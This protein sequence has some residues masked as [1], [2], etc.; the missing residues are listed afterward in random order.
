M[1]Y[2]TV[3]DVRGRV[4]YRVI[5]AGSAPSQTQVETWITESE[6]MLD[7]TLASVGIPGPFGGASQ[8]A[9]LRAWSLDYPEGHVRMAY[10]AAGGD[11]RND[12]G[13][14][15]LD[16]FYRRLDW[17][18]ENPAQADA[19]LNPPSSSDPATGPASYWTAG[20]RTPADRVPEFSRGDT[21]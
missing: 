21:L 19:M 3:V 14:D 11:G 17:I 10:A 1:S 6:A 8:I 16:R 5:D 4:P 15:L 13:K 12:D 18:R 20:G 2:S 7:S 9:I